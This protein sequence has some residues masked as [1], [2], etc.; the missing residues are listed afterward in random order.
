MLIGNKETFAVEFTK[1][2]DDQRM[3]YGKLWL[4]NAFL[5]TK[6][7]LIY[8]N[9]Y[10]VSLLNELIQAQTISFDTGNKSSFEVFELIRSKNYRSDYAIVGS[11]FTDDFEIY[12]FK[13]EEKI[14]VFWRLYNQEMIF[15]ELQQYPRE[16]QT[17]QINQQEIEGVK[18]KLLNEIK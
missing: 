2:E 8:L 4:Q 18:E 1:S 13:N 5:G 16:I 11:T 6:E 12:A 17:A 7:D 14:V 3:G 10:L 9:G 15:E